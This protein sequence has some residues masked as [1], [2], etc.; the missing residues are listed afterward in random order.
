[1]S[2]D[3]LVPFVINFTT[4]RGNWTAQEWRTRKQG[5]IPAYGKPTPE[6]IQK[7][8]A[9]VETSTAPGGVN[10]HMGYTKILRAWVVNQVSGEVVG[11]W[12][13]S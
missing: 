8:C 12:S 6:N 9:V 4:D 3:R 13:R 5:R 1:M 7:H 10:S 11:E 2:R